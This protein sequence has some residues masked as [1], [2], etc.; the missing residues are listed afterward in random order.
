MIEYIYH[1]YNAKLQER[2]VDTD[3]DGGRRTDREGYL[4]ICGS[5]LWQTP[6]K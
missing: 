2:V 4:N 1:A 5:L 6:L 3:H